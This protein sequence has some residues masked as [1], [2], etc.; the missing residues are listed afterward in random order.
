MQPFEPRII[1]VNGPPRAGKDTVTEKLRDLIIKHTDL[2]AIESKFTCPMD[3]IFKSA[4]EA[5]YLADKYS[6]KEVRE[7]FK[8]QEVMHK[9]NKPRQALIDLS[10]K[11]FKEYFGP[12]VFGRIAA[13]EVNR[14]YKGW[15]GQSVFL[16]SDSG[17]YQEAYGLYGAVDPYF[18]DKM[19][20]IQVHRDGCTFENDSRN[21][22][23]LQDL[24]IPLIQLNNSGSLEK[25]DELCYNL[26]HDLF[27]QKPG[28]PP[29]SDD[30]PP[31]S[32]GSSPNDTAGPAT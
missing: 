17:F 8:D 32:S 31:T 6:F 22:L 12:T 28:Q 27:I 25:L 14:T 2:S 24:G 3:Q 7:T 29:V 19:V 9:G 1:F 11:W 30:T 20:V 5:C 21:W 18:L 13:A 23:D 16:F 10:E 26:F 15:P 4:W